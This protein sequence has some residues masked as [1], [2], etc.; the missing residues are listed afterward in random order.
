[1]LRKQQREYRRQHILD[2]TEA[3]IRETNGTDFTMVE[4]ARRARMSEPT[5]YNLFGGKGAIIYALL[6]GAMDDLMLGEQAYAAGSAAAL[7]PVVAMIHAA[8]FFIADPELFR[9]LFKYQLGEYAYAERPAYMDRALQ[10]WRTSLNALVTDGTLDPALGGSGFSRDD[11]AIPLLAQSVGL[12]DLWV[13][14]EFTDDEFRARMTISAALIV[15]PAVDAA[16]RLI[17]D[18]TIREAR[19]NIRQDFS[20]QLVSHINSSKP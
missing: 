9:P 6:N 5:P 10:Y 8:E 11:L 17:L 2:V 20:F 16:S 14:G 1:M 12:L 7:H 3:L 13:Q 15:Y 4:V 19:S 18:R